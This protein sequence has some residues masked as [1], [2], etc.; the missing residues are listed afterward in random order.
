MW[1]ALPEEGQQG[2]QRE[3][4]QARLPI[5]CA[6]MRSA[7]ALV[8]YPGSMLKKVMQ[9]SRGRQALASQHEQCATSSTE[10][11][12]AQGRSH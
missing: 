8:C 2:R 4:Q 3:P 11:G 10:A 12:S 9:L 6:D 7:N 5:A 1:G